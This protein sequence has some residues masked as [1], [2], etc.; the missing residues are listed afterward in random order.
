M[1]NYTCPKCNKTTY[2]A[3]RDTVNVCPY[4]GLEKLIIFNPRIF[5]LGHNLSHA[6]VLFERRTNDF[7]VETDRRADKG[8]ESIPIAWLVIKQNHPSAED[9]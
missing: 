8:S 4:C 1:E 7:H 6:K 3:R 2:T 9:A 5:S